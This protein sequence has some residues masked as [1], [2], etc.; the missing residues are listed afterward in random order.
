MRFEYFE[1]YQLCVEIEFCT[2]H[3]E[4]VAMS[5]T[6]ATITDS[7]LWYSDTLNFVALHLIQYVCFKT[8]LR[9]GSIGAKSRS[10]CFSQTTTHYEWWNGKAAQKDIRQNILLFIL[11]HQKFHSKSGVNN[12]QVNTFTLQRQACGPARRSL[13]SIKVP[14]Q[15]S[16]S[17]CSLAQNVSTVLESLLWVLVMHKKEFF[18]T[19]QM[20]IFWPLQI[21]GYGR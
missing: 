19:H 3:L 9:A 11:N 4:R 20:R 17:Q 1:L 18:L 21:V 14:K 12:C 6:V 7:V 15:I 16:C 5:R 10:S 13:S 8:D 2:S